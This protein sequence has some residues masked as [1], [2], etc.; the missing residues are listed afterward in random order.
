MV[1]LATMGAQLRRAVI[2][3]FI[4]IPPALET[5]AL[6]LQLPAKQQGT[7]TR[8]GIPLRSSSM[9]GPLATCPVSGLLRAQI[10]GPGGQGAL[11]DGPLF[12]RILPSPQHHPHTCCP[13]QS[14]FQEQPHLPHL[15]QLETGPCPGHLIPQAPKPGSHPV[16]SSQPPEHLSN[17]FS[18]FQA[19]NPSLPWSGLHPLLPRFLPQPPPSSPS[20]RPLLPLQRGLPE[21]QTQSSPSPLRTIHGSSSPQVESS[22]SC[23]QPHSKLLWPLTLQPHSL[24]WCRAHLWAFVIQLFLPGVPSSLSP[25][26][27]CHSPSETFLESI[28]VSPA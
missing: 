25:G 4:V 18:H 20:V 23:L 8:R 10:P 19:E 11:P 17:L 22:G 14:P 12:P 7:W 5:G 24:P 21:A 6:C 9:P 28:S 26:G 13:S 2:I 1:Y 27:R 3:L 15:P 16:L